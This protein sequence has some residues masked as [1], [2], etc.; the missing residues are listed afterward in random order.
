MVVHKSL[1]ARHFTPCH[2]I[3]PVV[4]VVPINIII[5]RAFTFNHFSKEHFNCILKRKSFVILALVVVVVILALVVVVVILALMPNRPTTIAAHT[6]TCQM[7]DY[8]TQ[9]LSRVR[10]L[11]VQPPSQRAPQC[12]DSHIFNQRCD[13]SDSLFKVHIEYAATHQ[14]YVRAILCS[15]YTH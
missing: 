2:N 5:F 15:E 7:D 8:V 4:N 1:T 10:Q 13:D 9:C 12:F 11:E 6:T 3:W 14:F